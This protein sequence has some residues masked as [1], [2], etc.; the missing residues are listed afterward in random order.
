VSHP[1]ERKKKKSGQPTDFNDLH[2]LRGLSVVRE[3]L[4]AALATY[5]PI[6]PAPLESAEPTPESDGPEPPEGQKNQPFNIEMMLFRF[7]LVL[8]KTDIWD[9]QLKLL[10]KKPAFRDLVGKDLSAQWLA[11]EKKRTI[12]LENVKSAQ[13]DAAA[14]SVGGGGLDE[15][16]LRYVL[17]YGTKDVWDKRVR[18]RL[19]AETLRLAWPN[20][21]DLWL[22]NPAKRL[23][24]MQDQIVF[25]PTQQVGDECIN[26]FD[27]LPLTPGDAK[28]CHDKCYGIRQL[29]LEMCECDVSYQFVLRWLALPLQQ[30]GT[31]LAT[32]ILFY[33]H[34]QGAGKSLFFSEIMR[35][36]Y[37]DKYSATLGQND[38][39]SQYTDF[40]SGNLYA[41]FEEIFNPNDRL[42]HM[43]LI[44]H[45]ISGSR[46]R[47]QKKFVNGWEEANYS[48]CVFLSNENQPLP[49]EPNDRRFLVCWPDHK[50]PADIF[51]RAKAEMDAPDKEGV[52]A[53]YAYL[54]QLPMTWTSSV[55]NEDGT[56]REETFTFHTHLEPPMTEAK[57]RLIEYGL[58]GWQV[59]HREWKENRLR[60]PYM[61]CLSQHLYQ[62]YTR[63]CARS[64]ERPL[65]M[66]KFCT[67]ISVYERKELA[68]YTV[69]QTGKK[70]ATVIVVGQCPADQ[71]K[72]DW[73]AS[74]MKVFAESLGGN[75]SD[76]M[77]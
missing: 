15:M 72:Q 53:F 77:C 41:V 35:Q 65:T 24:V 60:W 18:T 48:N 76:Q 25:D 32:A 14:R 22:K 39:T 23:M 38:L 21:Y 45:Q 40:K 11:H 71:K 56:W 16:F 50:L 19:P 47:I 34:V 52:R 67:N 1:F 73:L 33:G 46:H 69:G 13:A 74:E 42:Q 6:L 64:G 17:I 2:I 27:G 58:P 12:S 4:Q 43:G 20:E 68:W 55:Q 3:Q 54:L 59:F 29:L 63:F 36:M 9:S 37:G 26:T 66:T 31:K 51:Q 7:A 8:G 44:K 49:I 62:A 5:K 70:Q 57:K 28:T 61:T 75:E 10:M 30:P